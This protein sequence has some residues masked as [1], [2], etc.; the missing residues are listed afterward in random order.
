MS[1]LMVLHWGRT[2]A[3]PALTLK[4]IQELLAAGEHEVAVSYSSEADIVEQFR[5]LDCPKFEV[6]TWRSAKDVPAV[7][8][9][10]PLMIRGLRRFMAEQGI[11]TTVVPME[12]PLQ[13]AAASSFV[14]QGARYVHFMHDASLHPGEQSPIVAALRRLHVRPVD[15]VMVFSESVRQGAVQ[16]WKFHP[17]HVHLSQLPP[18]F[19]NQM[20][21]Q[22][23]RRLPT[24]RPVVCGMFGRAV[25]YKGFDLAVEAVAALRA[26][27]RDVQLR[28]VGNGV[29]AFIPAQH[30]DA[31][32]LQVEDRWLA[33]DEI[34][35][36]MDTFDVLLLPYKEASQS[37]V[38]AEAAALGL[39]VVT[40]PVGGLPEQL[41]SLQCGEAATEVSAS[42]V[43]TAIDK[44]LASP[45][46]YHQCSA[47]GQAAGSGE[48]MWAALLA[49]LEPLL[50]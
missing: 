27:G 33:D 2:A 21:A 20:G 29:T 1:K 24:D 44:L 3:G 30:R 13:S 26:R 5:A 31:E 42:A 37:G 36:V 28:L 47:N 9:R 49:D 22:Q 11:T 34:V 16:G 7:A 15:E 18:M 32:W 10:L 19:S 43:A 25:E 35:G 39:P 41:N 4:L 38:L 45:E 50:A 17:E 40:T 46:H 14:S 23:P 6:R 48:K 12:H 8:A